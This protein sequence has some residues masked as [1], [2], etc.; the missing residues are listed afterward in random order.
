MAIHVTRPDKIGADI[1]RLFQVTNIQG[2]ELISALES[3]I[4]NLGNHWKGSDAGANLADLAKVYSYIKEYVYGVQ[5]LIVDVNNN[6]VIPLLNH[7]NFSGGSKYSYA[8]IAP[9]VDNNFVIALP[10]V[11]TEAWTSDEILK[12][13]TEFSTFPTKLATFIS[14][15]DTEKTVL[16]DNWKEGANRETVVRMF[17]EYNSNYETHKSAVN[18]VKEHLTT[19]ANNKRALL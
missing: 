19:V 12:D 9:T 6:E 2:K 3:T 7:I 4:T 13:E 17:N 14:A 10:P 16:L 15:L 18:T 1:E 5:N 8:D 11:T